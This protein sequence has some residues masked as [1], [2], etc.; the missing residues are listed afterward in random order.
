MKAGQ[1]DK[2]LEHTELMFKMSPKV[3]RD[4]SATAVNQIIDALPIDLANNADMQSKMYTLIT[5]DPKTPS[6]FVCING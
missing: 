5:N 4:E 6:A 2:M 3:S 1:L